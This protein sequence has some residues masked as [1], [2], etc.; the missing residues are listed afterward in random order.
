ME[1]FDDAEA[2][3]LRALARRKW[4]SV[5]GGST[6][7]VLVGRPTSLPLDSFHGPSAPPGN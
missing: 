1:S 2:L 3:E 5:A 7:M 4:L 6:R